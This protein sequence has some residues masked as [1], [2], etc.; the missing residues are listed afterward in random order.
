MTRRRLPVVVLLEKLCILSQLLEPPSREA[1]LLWE[2]APPLVGEEVPPSRPLLFLLQPL[3]GE[4]QAGA[5]NVDPLEEPD[6]G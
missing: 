3:G 4:V 1:M 2:A 5:L 6:E